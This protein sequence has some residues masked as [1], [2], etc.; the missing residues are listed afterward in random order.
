MGDLGIKERYA[1][2]RISEL[3]PDNGSGKRW[4]AHHLYCCPKGSLSLKNHLLFRDALRN[5]PELAKQYGDLKKKLASITDDIDVYVESKSAF[6]AD[7]LHRAGLSPVQ[8]EA[9]IAQNKKLP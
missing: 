3:S 1:F 4:P 7:V 5:E 2:E 9:I 6:I 8:L